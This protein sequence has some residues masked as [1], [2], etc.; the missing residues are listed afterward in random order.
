MSRI[1][2]RNEQMLRDVQAPQPKEGPRVNT[3]RRATRLYHP[4]DITP[5]ITHS[6][7]VSQRSAR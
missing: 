4:P 7:D 1:R 6:G 2:N 5:R 3:E